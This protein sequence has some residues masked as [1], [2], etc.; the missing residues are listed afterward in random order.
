MASI[1]PTGPRSV[2]LEFNEADRELALIAG[3]RPILKKSQWDGKD[4]A[5][6]ALDDIP[7]GSAPYVVDRFEVD[8]TVVL[9]RNPEYWGSNLALRQGTSNFD[10]IRIEFY[11]DNTVMN[12]A[13]K[14]QSLSYIREL[15]AEKWET[16][17]NFPAVQRGDI[18]KSEIPHQQPSGMAGFVIN[19]RHPPL[20]D[21]RVRD[22]LIHAFNFEIYQ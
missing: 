3:L 22:A 14:A 13:F 2:R 20:D 11:G 9:R 7:I 12:E 4:F 15:N 6:S 17:Y 21:W 5:G 18:V 1:K 8:R 19:T 10:E 16:Q